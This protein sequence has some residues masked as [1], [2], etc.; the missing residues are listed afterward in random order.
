MG[1]PRPGMLERRRA[2][3]VLS[4][5]ADAAHEGSVWFPPL[6]PVHT[7]VP[8]RAEDGLWSPF[9]QQPLPPGTAVPGTAETPR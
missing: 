8:Y 1:A 6:I 4:A 2:R 9:C 5:G 7:S 3:P